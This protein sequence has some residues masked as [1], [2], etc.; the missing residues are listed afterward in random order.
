MQQAGSSS[1]TYRCME[2][3]TGLTDHIVGYCSRDGNLQACRFQAVPWISSQ[4]QQQLVAKV[5][6]RIVPHL[7]HVVCEVTL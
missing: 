1:K 6:E 5:H 4:L 2:V 7:G 3:E